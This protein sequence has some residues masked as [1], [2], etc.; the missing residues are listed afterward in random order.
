M[1]EQSGEM[2]EEQKE[3][4]R[5]GVERLTEILEKLPIDLPD[6][7]GEYGD[8]NRP[9]MHEYPAEWKPALEAYRQGIE[10][11]KQLLNNEYTRQLFNRKGISVEVEEFGKIEGIKNVPQTMAIYLKKGG[12][13]MRL[14]RVPA[15]S[16]A[17]PNR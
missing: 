17:S 4:P 12:N 7:R 13:K 14:G 10:D 3:A 15:F 1:K 9:R 2:P 6:R 8:D 5:S 11:L 16:L